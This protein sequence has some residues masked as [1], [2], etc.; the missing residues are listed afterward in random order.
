WVVPARAGADARDRVTRDNDSDQEVGAL[1]MLPKRPSV[2]GPEEN[3]TGDAWIDFVAWTDAAPGARVNLVHFSPGARTAWHAHVDGQTI[4]VTDGVG[5]VQSRGGEAM[6]I[7]AGDV[8]HTGPG[9]EHWHG[10]SRV[11]FMTH[12]T[13][14]PGDETTWGDHVTDD[15]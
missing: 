15:E 14:L 2:K 12:L 8:V 3:F 4:Y 9:E 1:E 6:A 10:A 11:N 13:V 5:F 7:R